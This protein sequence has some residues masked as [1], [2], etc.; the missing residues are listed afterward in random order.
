MAQ[1]HAEKVRSKV[2]GGRLEGKLSYMDLNTFHFLSGIRVL[3]VENRSRG[4]D[5]VLRILFLHLDIR[6]KT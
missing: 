2:I 4:A 5:R 6:R 3:V 1:C